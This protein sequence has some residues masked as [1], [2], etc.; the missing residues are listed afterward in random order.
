MKGV[1]DELVERGIGITTCEQIFKN[2]NIKGSNQKKIEFLE[3]NLT[4]PLALE[5]LSEVKTILSYCKDM[6]IAGKVRF[7]PELARGL[8]IYTGPVFEAFFKKST[9]TSSIAAGGRYD[10]IIG[11]FI[12]R[13][14][15]YPAVG[16]SIGV[17][18]ILTEIMQ[19]PEKYPIIS[20]KE[21]SVEVLLVPVKIPGES[22]IPII[23]K[24]RKAG[25]NC[26]FSLDRNIR[27]SLGLASSLNIPICLILG[28][29]ELDEKMVTLKNM[30]DGSQSQVP[31]SNLLNSV[32]EILNSL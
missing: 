2:L 17:D 16:I 32:Q 24:L 1:Q 8:E 9:I 10:K 28:K 27:D 21:T 12:D 26:D 4:N 5:G 14:K 6:K 30:I 18:V 15:I 20:K 31:V 19:S 7:R 13:D 11:K 25:I 3:K 22:L 29:R 23:T